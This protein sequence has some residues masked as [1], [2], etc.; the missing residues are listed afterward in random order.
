[1]SRRLTLLIPAIA[2]FALLWAPAAHAAQTITVNSTADTADTSLADGTCNAQCTLRSAI[3]TANSAQSPGADTIILPANTYTRTVSGA[4]TTP[5]ASIGDLDVTGD[6][7]ITGAG[8]STTIIDGNDMERVFD[9]APGATATISGVTI[10]GGLAS[11]GFGPSTAGG[12]LRVGEHSN[13]DASLTLNDVTLSANAAHDGSG[14]ATDSAASTLTLNR[15]NVLDN[16]ASPAGGSEGGGVNERGGTVAINNSLIRGNH[17]ASGG[18]VTDD[19]FDASTHGTITITDT[20]VTEN[21]G[22]GQ[23]G[24]VEETGTG[25]VTI[26]R[27]T[28]SKNTSGEGAGV[29]EDGAGTVTVIDS[30]IRENSATAGFND[31]GG[32]LR[33]GGGNVTIQGSL[34]VGNTGTTGAGIQD[35]GGAGTFAVTNSTL[36]GNH[37]STRGGAIQT[38]GAGAIS[39]TNVTLKDNVSDAGAHEIDNCSAIPSCSGPPHTVTLRNTIVA[40]SGTNCAGAITS[41]GH[42]LDSGS[43]CGLSASGDL[44]NVDP[45]VGDL[46]DNGGPTLTFA[47]L[48]GSPAIDAGET[49]SCPQTDQRGVGRPAGPVCDIGA[50]E[51]A[52]AVVAVVAP[53]PPSVN[54]PSVTPPTK[55]TDK[56][57]PITT[58]KRRGLHLAADGRLSLR[59]RS[60]DQKKCRSGVRRVQVSIARVKGRTGTNCRFIRHPNRYQLT[61][62]KNCRRPT[63]FKAKGTKKWA[64]AFTLR[65]KPGLYRVQARATDKARNKETPKKRRNIVF[66]SVK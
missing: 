44:S 36:T 19:G 24:G 13:G 51:R 23:G 4:D 2:T 45:K 40:G 50:F 57:P 47:E 1:M 21:V 62:P 8:Q 9:I 37:A 61:A 49:A 27:S 38:D 59:G 55:C 17:A 12:G 60:K 43:T 63:L 28:V 65:L 25:N 52:L 56:L 42:N 20:T 5:D 22:T 54:P 26:T 3:Q 39:L 31:G 41:G 18:G 7:T 14:V 11:D 35:F 6:L 32:V 34:I 58:L 15:V 64:F 53:P 10:T 48:D 29:V 33:D 30:T 16:I 46:A 66:F